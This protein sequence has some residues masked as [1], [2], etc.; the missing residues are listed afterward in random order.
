MI[1]LRRSTDDKAILAKLEA[2]YEASRNDPAK[3]KTGGNSMMARLEALQ[4]EQERLQK[5]QQQRNK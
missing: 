1:W 4:K 2:D 5:Q 3:R